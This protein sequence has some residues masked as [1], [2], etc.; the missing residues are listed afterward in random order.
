MLLF[1]CVNHK[2]ATRN[3]LYYER[4]PAAAAMHLPRGHTGVSLLGCAECSM[5]DLGCD[6]CGVAIIKK[7]KKIREEQQAFQQF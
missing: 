6:C 2:A 7:K 5:R 3:R 1:R 4:R